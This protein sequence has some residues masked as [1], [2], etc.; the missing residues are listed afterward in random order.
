MILEFS[1]RSVGSNISFLSAIQS[2]NTPC[3]I[4]SLDHDNIGRK[5]CPPALLTNLLGIFDIDKTVINVEIVDVLP[6]DLFN[7]VHDLTKIFSPYLVVDYINAFGCRYNTGIRNIK[8]NQRKPCIA[9][10]CF[11]SKRDF[12]ILTDNGYNEDYD[13]FPKNRHYTTEIN[14]EIFNF[15][16]K[17]GYDVINLDSFQ[18][19][20]EHKVFIL[21][22]LCDAVV[23]YE[24][25]LAHIAHVLKIPTIILPW[26]N[27]DRLQQHLLHLDVKSYFANSV[28]EVLSWTR[29]DIYE[30]IGKLD[31]NQTNNLFFNNP[32]QW[33]KDLNFV[34][35]QLNN[36]WQK[37]YPGLTDFE[38][39][40]I[41]KN[42]LDKNGQLFLNKPIQYCN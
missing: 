14:S 1:P 18:I 13:K 30:I 29:D 16:L 37:Y 34:Q 32:V 9:L 10:G 5:D 3:I 11:S 25:G 6:N 38:K 33:D 22:E 27:G 31:N 24:G 39:N 2:T 15:L 28:D 40:L 19:S 23:T 7:Q 20:L 8:Y 42:I 36:S 21:N 35:V 12:E 26:R 17:C 4:K 41:Q